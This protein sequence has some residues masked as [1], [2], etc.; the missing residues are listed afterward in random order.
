MRLTASFLFFILLFSCQ[1]KNIE[2]VKAVEAEAPG[3]FNGMRAYYNSMDARGVLTPLDT[4]IIVDEKFS[5]DFEETDPKPQLRVITIDG[6]E[7]NLLF[8]THKEGV[9]LAIKK[10]SLPYSTVD[11][12]H[13]NEAMAVYQ[14][15]KTTFQDYL[16]GLAEERNAALRK[17]DTQLVNQLTSAYQKRFNSFQKNMESLHKENLDNLVGAMLLG[18]LLNMKA[19]DATT[20]REQ[21]NKLSEDVQAQGV[22]KRIDEYLK[23]IEI[24]AIGAKAPE[25][26][27][28]NPDGE[29]IKLD[30]VLGKVT[31][32]DFWA[33]WCGPCR[34]ENPNV[35]EAYKKYHDKGFNIISVSLDRENGKQAW[36]NAIEKDGMNWNHVSRLKYFGP[37]AKLYNVNSIPATFLLDE[38]GIIIDKN[39]RGQALHD[40]LEELL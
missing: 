14:S 23:K 13:A 7:K 35:V 40:R 26:E 21:F 3:I 24:V 5:F 6:V 8:L 20:G 37:L 19:Y 22:S 28:F 12:G 31:L 30:E 18:E 16:K 36:I 10:D 29:V 38:N 34:R 2:P 33:S 25:F 39:L 17:Q 4:S 11:G 15:E 32:V 9:K 1:E 27:G